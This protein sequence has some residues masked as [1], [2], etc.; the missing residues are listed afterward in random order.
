MRPP[1]RHLHIR[2][3]LFAFVLLLI[4]IL[5][6]NAPEPVRVDH[7]RPNNNLSPYLTSNI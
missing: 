3:S 4:A 7:I 5:D 1:F 6:K 2:L